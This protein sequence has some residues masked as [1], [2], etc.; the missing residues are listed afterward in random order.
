MSTATTQAPAQAPGLAVDVKIVP[1]GERSPLRTDIAGFIG[2]TLR[3]PQCRVRVQGQN[4]FNATFGDSWL[5]GAV[6]PYAVN[7]YFENEGKV[8]HIIRVAGPG[9][10]SASALW[11]LTAKQNQPPPPALA[12]GFCHARYRFSASS[13]GAWANGAQVTL[14]YRRQGVAGTP[15]VDVVTTAADETPETIRGIAPEHFAKQINDSSTLIHVSGVGSEQAAFGLGSLLAT[16]TLTLSGGIDDEP[17]AQSYLDAIQTMGDEREVAFLAMPDLFD[18]IAGGDERLD[19]IAAAVA[20]ADQQMDRLVLVDVPSDLS[21]S[22][23]VMAWVAKL[24]SACIAASSANDPDTPRSA[25]VYHPWLWVPDPNGTTLA[26]ARKLLPPSGHV[27][28]LISRLDRQRGAYYTPANAPVLQAVDIAQGVR[29]S[30]RAV[31]NEAGVNLIRCFPNQGLLVWGGRTLGTQPGDIFVAHR[32]LLHRLVRAIRAVAE[33]LVFDVNGPQLWLTLVRAITTVLLQA[34]RSGALAGA[35]PAEAFTVQCDDQT[36]TPDAIAA[37]RVLC[38][39]SV[40]PATPMEF[41]QLQVTLD[42]LGRVG[43]SQ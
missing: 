19:I 26:E 5:N 4:G 9:S 40:A 12:S 22:R 31:L 37:G 3:G 35:S 7:G 14:T 16:T 36:N 1:A 25:V 20:L 18:D 32:R 6:T 23:D 28:G 42:T 29:A 11:D 24:R 41:I 8:A 33:P 43:V 13:P 38:L 27:A 39:V 21:A 2:R 17:T 34:Y 10:Q 30:D 15:T